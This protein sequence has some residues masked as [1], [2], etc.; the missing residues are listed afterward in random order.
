MRNILEFFGLVRF[1]ESM[2]SYS[3]IALGSL[4]RAAREPEFDLEALLGFV[5]DLCLAVTS[6]RTKSHHQFCTPTVWRGTTHACG[7]GHGF[8]L[9]QLWDGAEGQ[10]YGEPLL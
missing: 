10:P 1:E 9:S 5:R 6:A 2:S 4:N 3:V 8:L 7:P